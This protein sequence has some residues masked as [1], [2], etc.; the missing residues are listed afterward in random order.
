[1]SS[2]RVARLAGA[3]RAGGPTMLERIASLEVRQQASDE[4]AETH[5]EQL[6]KIDGKVQNLLDLVQ[7]ATGIKMLLVWVVSFVGVTAATVTAT[8]AAIR[9][10]TGG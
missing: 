5:G 9:Y 7:R 4:R 6:A 3:A 10:F 8:I 1:M 2:T